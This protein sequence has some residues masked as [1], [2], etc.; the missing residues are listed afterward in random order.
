MFT[1][2]AQDLFDHLFQCLQN[3]ER[4]SYGDV[5]EQDGVLRL[6]VQGMPSVYVIHSHQTLQQV[7][8]SSPLSGGLHFAFDAVRKGW[9]DTRTDQELIAI[10]GQELKDYLPTDLWSTCFPK[11]A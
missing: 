10:L 1:Q 8:V 2:R 6:K 5:D 3:I 4:A 9:Y 7:W 11:H